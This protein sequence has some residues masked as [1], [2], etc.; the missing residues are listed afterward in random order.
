MS[1]LPKETTDLFSSKLAPHTCEKA[2][3]LDLWA[4]LS[5]ADTQIL[6]NCVYRKVIMLSQRIMYG[7][8]WCIHLHVAHFFCNSCNPMEL[9]YCSEN[10]HNDF[11]TAAVETLKVMIKNNDKY[12]STEDA[13]QEYVTYLCILFPQHVTSSMPYGHHPVITHHSCCCHLVP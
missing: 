11:A 2:G 4:V 7:I 12:L 8:G 6:V 3:T 5:V 10:W 13:I 9:S 1:H